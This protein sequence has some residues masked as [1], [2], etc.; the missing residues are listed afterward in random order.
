M[1][2]SREF[3][4]MVALTCRAVTFFPQIQAPALRRTPI[5][6]I[7]EGA[8]SAHDLIHRL[9]LLEPQLFDWASTWFKLYVCIAI[10]RDLA[11]R[12]M[13]GLP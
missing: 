6:H 7:K 4:F 11:H 2:T 10:C 3:F 5:N 13:S 8:L 9:G 12:R 1:K